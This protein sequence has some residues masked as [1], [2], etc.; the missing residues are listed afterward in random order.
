MQGVQDLMDTS[1][2]M[3]FTS[4]KSCPTSNTSPDRLRDNA[5]SPPESISHS[6]SDHVHFDP[7]AGSAWNSASGLPTLAKLPESNFIYAYKTRLGGFFRR[8]STSI[9]CP[10]GNL[11]QRYCFKIRCCSDG[12]TDFLESPLVLSFLAEVVLFA[13]LHGLHEKRRNQMKRTIK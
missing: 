10:N 2:R 8:A 5:H 13:G 3:L 7:G 12:K 11:V 6:K 4:T 1:H 9:L